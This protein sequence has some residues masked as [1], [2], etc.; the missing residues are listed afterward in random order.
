[1]AQQQTA[2]RIATSLACLAACVTTTA[3]AQVPSKIALTG[4]RIITVSGEDIA[5]GSVLVEDGRI[6]AVG[7]DLEIPYDAIEY[8]VSGKVVFPG[9]I[10]PHASRGMD[11]RNETLPV[12][13][14]LNVYD[15]IDPSRRYFEDA[16][17]DGVTTV[18]AIPDNDTVVGGVSRVVKPIGLSIDEMTV[19]PDLA[20]KMSTTPK[21]GYD[22]MRQLLEL[23]QTFYRLDRSLEDLAEKRYEEDQEE[24]GKTA[25]IP[26]EER[27]EKGKELVRDEDLGDDTRNLVR[28]RRGDLDAWIYA[29]AAMD[30]GPALELAEQ[31]ELTDNAV[32]VLGVTAHKAVEELKQAGR[33][34]VL[35]AELFH[36][37]RDPFSGE[38]RETF[39]PKK[40]H[41]AGVTFALQPSP[42]TSLAERYLNYQAAV[43]VRNGVPRSEALKA[44][45]LN[46]AEMLGL[47]DRLGSIEAGK[48]GNLVVFSGDPLDFGSWV[49]MVFIDG[50]LAYDRSKDARLM[51][52][53]DLERANAERE[54]K[55]NEDE[56]RD[57]ESSEDTPSEDEPADADASGEDAPGGDAEPDS[58]NGEGSEG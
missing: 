30:V 26:P 23:R 22:R 42:S 4:A 36:R 10:D 6:T 7:E 8:D 57:E 32:L 19:E 28:L 55:E 37:E 40:L 39:V 21:R 43:C 9:M 14:F 50:V 11:V 49:E 53:L 52:L 13:P 34:V 38:V 29:G 45:T 44:I 33:P 46:P 16:L 1:M 17:R 27:R 31:E 47:G 24:Q 5:E 2:R 20:M 35:P 3:W 12:T 56:Q 25:R 51:E 58:G 15:A 41:E 54:A 48:A 18:H